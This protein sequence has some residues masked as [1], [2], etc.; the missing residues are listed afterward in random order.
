[1]TIEELLAQLNTSVAK[2]VTT[3]QLLLG[4]LNSNIQK[5]LATNQ[6]QH[7]LDQRSYLAEK[8]ILGE[9]A[10]GKGAYYLPLA[11]GAT[12]TLTI[13]NIQ[14]HVGFIH[15]EWVGVSQPGVISLTIFHD[16]AITPWVFIPALTDFE[17]VWT[18]ALPYGNITKEFATVT[19][20]NNDALPQWVMGAMLGTYLRKE[21]W[22]RDSSIMRKMAQAF[23]ITAVLPVGPAPP[24]PPIGG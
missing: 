19:Y 17:V 22:E 15:Q 10:I 4:Q 1:M 5:L 24:L 3:N 18:I 2:L 16:D 14:G 12:A 13:P 23:G 21:I 11:P 20:V 9:A 6:L 8:V 7:I